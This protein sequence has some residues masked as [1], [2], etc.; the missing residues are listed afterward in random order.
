MSSLSLLVA[1]LCPLAPAPT[2]APAVEPATISATFA[3]DEFPD[4]WFW[5]QGAIG[6][7]HK[8]MTGKAPPALEVT[9]WKGDASAIEALVGKDGKGNIWERLRGRVVVVDFWATWCGPCMA[10]LPENV[11]LTREHAADGLVVIGVHDSARGAENIPEAMTANKINYPIAIDDAA[12]SVRAWKVGFWPTYAVIDRKGVVRALGLKPNNV[13]AVV[14]KLLKENA[15][16]STK[17]EQKNST[18]P[19]PAAPTGSGAINPSGAIKPSGASTVRKQPLPREL[20]EGDGRR[21]GAVAKFDRCPDAPS[22]G[23]ISHWTPAGEAIGKAAALE[24]LK[25]K[26]VVIDFWATWCAPCLAA[27]PK[28]NELARKYADKGVVFLGVCHPEG[29][30]KMLDIV[31]AKGVE[32]TVCLDTRGEGIANYAVDSYPDYYIIDRDGRLRGADV[33]NNSVAAA[34]DALLAEDA[35]KGEGAAKP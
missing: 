23:A 13:R 21:R 15:V 18:K 17:G 26:I 14:E 32:Y 16:G 11:A 35:A 7:A 10:A 5:R 6:T 19:A 3:A 27:I 4:D 33:G 22:L 1:L 2:A 20:L 9:Q 31:R 34:I 30:E 28:N 8:A 25:G 24:E 29:G 12:K